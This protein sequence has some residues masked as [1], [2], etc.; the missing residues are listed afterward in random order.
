MHKSLRDRAS[1]ELDAAGITGADKSTITDILD[2]FFERFDSGGAVSVMAPVLARLITGAPLTPITGLDHEWEDMSE[3]EDALPGSVYQNNRATSVFK[4]RI[5]L[6][7]YTGVVLRPGDPSASLHATSSR[8]HVQTREQID[9]AV[10]KG[11]AESVWVFYDVNHPCD[12]A[13]GFNGFRVIE[14][15]PYMPEPTVTDP[16]VVL[17]GSQEL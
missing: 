12:G 13:G 1:D 10:Q 3:Y 11:E 14:Q 9:E 7:K 4:R 8:H 17:P 15:F 5:V 6:D 16:V 2:L